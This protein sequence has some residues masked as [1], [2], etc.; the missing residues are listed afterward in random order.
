MEIFTKE[1]HSHS[2]RLAKRGFYLPSGLTISGKDINYV[3]NVLLSI[4]EP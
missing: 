1:I 4:I 2:E 3:S